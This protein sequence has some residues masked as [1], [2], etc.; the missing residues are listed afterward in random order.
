MII[1]CTVE[2]QK[3]ECYELPERDFMGKGLDYISRITLNTFTTV[4][5]SNATHSCRLKRLEILCSFADEVN[6]GCGTMQVVDRAVKISNRSERLCP[7]E[8]RRPHVFE[9]T[10]SGKLGTW[11]S[12]PFIHSTFA[13]KSTEDTVPLP[14]DELSHTRARTKRYATRYCN[15]VNYSLYLRQSLYVKRGVL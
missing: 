7:G 1:K 10:I 13:S 8:G 9:G 3:P 14:K 12:G 6:A 11:I 2:G 15:I 5:Q 4:G